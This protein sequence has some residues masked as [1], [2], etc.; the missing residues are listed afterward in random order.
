M[1][2]LAEK[3]VI[4]RFQEKIASKSL[5]NVSVLF[6]ES[7]GLSKNRRTVEVELSNKDKYVARL[8]LVAQPTKERRE[9]VGERE[10]LEVLQSI[11]DNIH[12]LVPRSEA[13]FP[14]D[15]KRTSFI[16]EVEGQKA[17]FFLPYE[18][19]KE[20]EEENNLTSFSAKPQLLEAIN[21][22]RKY[23]KSE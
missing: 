12:S 6:R 23:A 4:K 16:L 9:A 3:K 11:V 17:Q 7:G 20:D 10:K 21:V 18:E 2:N 5:K 13:A 22:F 14:P 15:C 8:K 19:D 1:P